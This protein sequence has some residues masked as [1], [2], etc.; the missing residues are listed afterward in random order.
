MRASFRD[1]FIDWLTIHGAAAKSLPDLI[2]SYCAFLNANGFAI[3]RCNLATDTI[4]PQMTGTRHVWFAEKTDPGPINPQVL[5]S[6]RQYS[7]G[8]AMIDEIFFNAQSQESPQYKASPFYRVEVEGELYDEVRPAGEQQPYPLFDDL[9]KQGCTAYYGKRLISFAGMLQ[10]IGMATKRDGALTP[11]MVADL[12][13]SLSLLTLHINTLIEY[14]I[15][16]TLSEVYLGRDPGHRVSSGMIEAGNVIGIEGAIW[17]SDLRGFTKAS[18]AYTPEQLVEILNTYFSLLAEPIYENEGEVLKYIGDAMMAVFPV[19]KFRS[20]MRA[21][22]AALAA[23]EAANCGLNAL[24]LQRKDA[25]ELPIAHGIGMH[26]GSAL[27]GNVGSAQRLDFTLI[28]REVNLASRLESLT[29]QTDHQLLVSEIF[30]RHSSQEM[31]SVGLFNLAGIA[32][33]IPVFAPS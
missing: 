10:K 9:Q 28:G 15:K 26:Y 20:P 16:N 4:H 5:V 18:E 27:Y 11:Q 13:W 8:K 12:G 14:A 1:Q 31:R 3:H 25:G 22:D 6:R 2:N 21:C 7:M 19:D 23:A 17:F 33:K 24:N 32:G 30:A 29:K